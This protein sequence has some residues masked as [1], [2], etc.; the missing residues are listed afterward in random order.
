MLVDTSI[1]FFNLRKVFLLKISEIS[2][3]ILI[4]IPVGEIAK[5][6]MKECVFVNSALKIHSAMLSKIHS[7]RLLF[8]DFDH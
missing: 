8:G 5:K 7:Y 2:F 3:P 4:H 6:S 1:V